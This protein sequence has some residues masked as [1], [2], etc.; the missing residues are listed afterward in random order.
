MTGKKSGPGPLPYPVRGRA[1]D[2]NRCGMPIVNL[3]AAASP[4]G[5]ERLLFRFRVEIAM[6]VNTAESSYFGRR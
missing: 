1:P 2:E 4:A 6:E 3:A 5:R